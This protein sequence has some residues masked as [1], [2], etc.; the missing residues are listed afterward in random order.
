MSTKK[1]SIRK[2]AVLGSGV[3]GSQIA[4]HCVNAG[5]DVVLLDLKSDDPIRPNKMV[6][7][8]LQKASKMKPAPFGKP[9]L[10]KRIEIGNFEDDFDE[11]KEADWI[12][13]VI[14]EKMD[15]KKDMMS[16]IEKVRKPETIVSSNTSGLPISEISEECSDDFKAHFLGT[17]FFNPPRYMKLLEV[18]PT[19]TTSEDVTEFMH[20]FC[21]KTLGKG[22]VICKDTPNFIANR[23][24]IFSIANIMPYF[25]DGDFRAEEIDLLTGTLTGY[26][27]AATFR[28]AD[29]A[30]LDVTN[31]VAK[32]LYPSIPDDEMR[33][34]FNLPKEFEKMVEEGII[35]NKAGK[36]F[37]TKQDGEYLVLNPKNFE[38]ESQQQL[39]DPILDEAKK[40]KDTEER[41]KF[42]VFSGEK[43][44]DFLWNVHRDLLLYAANRIPEITDSPLSIDRAMQWGF[45]WEMGPF[46]R[47]D[48]LGLNN[49]VER[50]EKEGAAVPELISE[51]LDAGI[52]SFYED[53]KV[54]DPQSKAM[55]DIPPEAKGEVKVHHL[56]KQKSPVME[57]NSVSLHDMGDGV[58]LFEFHTPNSTLGSEL[59]QSL[60]NSLD[61]VKDQFD[62]LVISHDA[63][64]FAFG[65][66]LKEA[67]VAKQNNDWDSV[68]EAVEN[69]QKTAV[70]L[71][72]APFPVVAAP[73]GKT[74]GGGVEFC[75]YSDKVVAHHEL[76][77]GLV[78]VG[79]GLIP[80][81]GGTTELLR[82]AMGKLEGDA[83]PLPFI[84]EVFKTI[85]MAKVSESAH[86]A[87]EL[88]YMRASDTIVMNRDLLIKRAKEEALNLVHAGYQSPAETP[89]KVLGKTAL[90]A[91]K[92]MLHVMHEGKY[93]TDYDKVVAERVA[94]VLAGGDLSEVQEVPES[95]LL[96]LERE[97]I[98][99]CLQ[100][101]RTLARMEHM[102]KK[103]K[104]L[105][106]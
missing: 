58:A 29:M 2:V 91:M 4:A 102:L 21:E 87:H 36:G 99:E 47:W 75:L 64:N 33:E 43:I 59:V 25:F 60:Y 7:E 11:L 48:A 71:R 57:N 46:E 34:T 20:R 76:Y 12:C 22:V 51:M 15:I 92:L 45:N 70:A 13:E 67:L 62:A 14:V 52:S 80:A 9:D 18:I 41:L 37:Y 6:E 40:I 69:F 93:I 23:I 38:Y 86:R 89:V 28:T 73:F 10:A 30:G 95:Y 103:G 54:Y 66:N 72:Y 5:L 8:S 100:D 17:H 32:N 50:L 24:G 55:V 105:R 90:S 44:G 84:R 31:H 42:L 39:E 79:V 74:L 63:D 94:Y 3:M 97:A 49:M 68:V 16:R 77:M 88:G 82:R 106:N 96:K 104:P 65:A 1:Y 19:A 27:K 56:R 35:G 61:T 83:D 81:G 85:G 98:L 53:G 26:S 101:D 78:E